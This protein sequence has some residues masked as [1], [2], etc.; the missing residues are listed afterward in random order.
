MVP[1]VMRLNLLDVESKVRARKKQR[2]DQMIEDWRQNNMA[3]DLAN[4][5]R[6]YRDNKFERCVYSMRSRAKKRGFPPLD[7]DAQF[8][9][10]LRIAQE[11]RCP[12]C[13]VHLEHVAHQTDG[14]KTG[15]E[16]RGGWSI[17]RI[18]STCG[19]IRDNI[20]IMC[21]RCNLLKRDGTLIEFERLVDYL[22]RVS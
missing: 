14:R 20:A 1:A 2:H 17:D 10:D 15:S 18:D 9:R 12:V 7:F 22:R 8:L 5:A 3:R 11:N 16:S 13:A 4:K 21:L 19:Y 6:Y